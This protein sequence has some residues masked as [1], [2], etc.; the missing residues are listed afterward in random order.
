MARTDWLDWVINMEDKTVWV[1]YSDHG[2][3]GVAV[4]DVEAARMLVQSSGLNLD[5]EEMVGYEVEGQRRSGYTSVRKAA[6]KCGLDVETFLVKAL[7][8]QLPDYWIWDC[9]IE[10]YAVSR[11][12]W[13]LT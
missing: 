10:E 2:M 9:S 12:L 4:S 6:E 3:D 13:P 5:D 11:Y 8:G 7:R 1:L